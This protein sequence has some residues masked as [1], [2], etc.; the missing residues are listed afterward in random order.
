MSTLL[1]FEFHGVWDHST[2]P[3]LQSEGIVHLPHKT[4]RKHYTVSPRGEAPV[5]GL[6][7]GPASVSLTPPESPRFLA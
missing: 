1:N 6:R 7:L 2:L 5:R 4:P 3:I